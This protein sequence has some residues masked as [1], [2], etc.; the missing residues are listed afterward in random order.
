[1]L[2]VAA[3]LP[4]LFWDAGPSTAPALRDAHIERIAVPS[5][6]ASAWKGV[7]GIS[8]QPA[9]VDHLRK[10]VV[11]SV[12]YRPDQASASR[13]PWIQ[14]NGWELVRSHAS[15]FYYDAPGKAAGLAAAEAFSYGVDA[16]IHTDAA[17]L[18][19]FAEMLAFL[20]GI[21]RLD[22]PA[23]ADIVFQD[24]GSDTA[25]EVL[26]L[27]LRNNLL[28]RIAAAPDLK[29]KL[30]VRLGSPQFPMET[31]QDPAAMAHLVRSALGDDH[32]SLRIY[33]TQVVLARV[34]SGGGRVRLALLNYD[35]AR[36]NV[37]GLHVRVLGRFPK[38]AAAA[39]GGAAQLDDYSTDDQATEFTLPELKTFAVIDLSR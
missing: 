7:A 35:G 34:T 39:P 14:S 19:P 32:R 4:L 15:H 28:V 38:H 31:A 36:R 29:A 6:Q 10:L 30:N 17:G 13:A 21:E 23:L 2:F 11:P 25:G 9:D 27:M 16:L 12:E 3:A 8:V 18:Q 26:N 1:M 37:N 22:M 24:D 5:A 33:G 20:R